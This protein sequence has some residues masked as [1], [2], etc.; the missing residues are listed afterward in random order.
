MVDA[1]MMFRVAEKVLLITTVVGVL[2]L[3]AMVVAW[4]VQ[5]AAVGLRRP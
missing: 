4:G 5:G 3:L 2:V 1:D